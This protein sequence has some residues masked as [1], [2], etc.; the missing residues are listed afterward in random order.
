M[1]IKDALFIL[2]LPPDTIRIYLGMSIFDI[3]KELDRIKNIAVQ[4]RKGLT[5]KY[6]EGAI[7][8]DLDKMK[9]INIVVDKIK[10]LTIDKFTNSILY[11]EQTMVTSNGKRKRETTWDGFY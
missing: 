2:E 6:H 5:K 1:Y 3:S 8:E 10:E 9:Q 7:H 11:G 4:Q